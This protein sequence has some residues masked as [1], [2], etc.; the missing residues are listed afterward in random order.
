VST[1]LSHRR[2]RARELMRRPLRAVQFKDFNNWLLRDALQ[3]DD[4]QVFAAFEEAHIQFESRAASPVDLR[5]QS[6]SLS[7]NQSSPAVSESQ[8]S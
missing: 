3:T 2:W 4:W 8:P 5:C 6:R 7:V 1:S